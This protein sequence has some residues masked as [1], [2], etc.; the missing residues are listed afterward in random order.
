MIFVISFTIQK[1]GTSANRNELL[2]CWK[3]VNV[4]GGKIQPWLMFEKLKINV[5]YLT[6]KSSGNVFLEKSLSTSCPKLFI[7]SFFVCF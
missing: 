1:K 2:N 7:C 6:D 5:L 4:N 3:W